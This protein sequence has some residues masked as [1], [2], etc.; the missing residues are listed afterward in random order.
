MNGQ[1]TNIVSFKLK[2]KNEQDIREPELIGSRGE[3]SEQNWIQKDTLVI[4]DDSLEGEQDGDNPASMDQSQLN[5]V[6]SRVDSLSPSLDDLP[7]PPCP[8]C[9]IRPILVEP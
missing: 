9:P 3:W 2:H 7:I 4:D 8:V 5:D 6:A 1:Q